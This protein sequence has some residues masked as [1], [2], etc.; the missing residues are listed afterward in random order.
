MKAVETVNAHKPASP[1]TQAISANGFLFVSGQLGRNLY[2]QLEPT[3]AGQAARAL[4]NLKAI[5]T[6]AGTSLDHVVK[7]TVFLT[8]L[9]DTPE[10]NKIYTSYFTG[11]LPTRSCVEVAKLAGGALVEVEAI[12]LHGGKQ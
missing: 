2:G 1:L 8:N 11:T 10:F 7:T 5:L 12:A 9:T 4:E 6:E 3:F